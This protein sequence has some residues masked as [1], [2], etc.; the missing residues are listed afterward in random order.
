MAT[1][2]LP[3]FL[4][5][6]LCSMFSWS[7]LFLLPSPSLSTATSL[8]TLFSC[9]TA[10]LSSPRTLPLISHTPLPPFPSRLVHT[11]EIFVCLDTSTA[12]SLC[13]GV[14]LLHCVSDHVTGYWIS[15]M[16]FAYKDSRLASSPFAVSDI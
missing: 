8:L 13:G 5:G 12:G 6:F 2:P 15:R 9:N 11:P 7:L 16:F 3:F 1:S 4:I 10:C 14:H